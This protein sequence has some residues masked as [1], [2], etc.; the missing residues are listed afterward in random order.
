MVSQLLFL[1]VLPLVNKKFLRGSLPE[2]LQKKKKC[3]SFTRGLQKPGTVQRKTG[4][5]WEVSR[6]TRSIDLRWEAL[7]TLQSADTV[8]R[9]ERLNISYI[10]TPSDMT[11]GQ[12]LVCKT[13]CISKPAVFYFTAETTTNDSQALRSQLQGDLPPASRARTESWPLRETRGRFWPGSSLSPVKPFRKRVRHLCV[14]KWR[15]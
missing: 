12:K 15:Q 7:I 5:C 8:M 10:N 1:A 13:P 6:A 11:H 4:V 9:S 14:R 3:T 2:L